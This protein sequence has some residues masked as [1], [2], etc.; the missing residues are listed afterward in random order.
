[1]S[2]KLVVMSEAANRWFSRHRYVSE[3]K[4]VTL[5][6]HKSGQVID[7]PD[8]SFTLLTHIIHNRKPLAL[9]IK[10]KENTLQNYVEIY[11]IKIHSGFL[12]DP[13]TF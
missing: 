8:G 2:V 13:K 5:V 10:A 3:E 4:I 6:I 9:Y 11:V 1:V 12:K 7:N